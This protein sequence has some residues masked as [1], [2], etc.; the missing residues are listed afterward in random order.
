MK[1]NFHVLAIF[2][3]ALLGC[4]SQNSAMDSSVMGADSVTYSADMLNVEFEL[5][6]SG[7]E[8]V[9]WRIPRD[10]R[11]PVFISD[12]NAIYIDFRSALTVSIPKRDCSDSWRVESDQISY[13]GAVE[14]Q[15]QMT[16]LNGSDFCV[17]SLNN[18]RL[19]GTVCYSKED[20]GFGIDRFIIETSDGPEIFEPE[21]QR[22][23]IAAD[24]YLFSSVV[25]RYEPNAGMSHCLSARGPVRGTSP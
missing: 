11:L 12:Y 13:D 10:I 17:R 15:C 8:T 9:S 22:L 7:S 1:S 2:S 18:G 19:Y 20:D 25:E 24:C 21:E 14:F 5:T 16:A 23:F 3:S 4:A 6:R